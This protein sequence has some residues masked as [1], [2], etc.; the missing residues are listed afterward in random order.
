MAAISGKGYSMSVWQYGTERDNFAEVYNSGQSFTV[1]WWYTPN[2][3]EKAAGAANR[4]V[5]TE[6][7]K[8][9]TGYIN[10]VGAMRKIREQK[11]NDRDWVSTPQLA[12]FLGI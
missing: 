1:V 4:Q 8:G 5:I 12:S 6:T 11:A 3:F 2:D 7:F 9:K 10:V